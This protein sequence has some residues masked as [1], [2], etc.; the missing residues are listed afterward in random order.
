CDIVLSEHTYELCHDHIWVRELD[1]I[2]VKG[3]MQPVKI[4]GLIG[5]R[6]QALDDSTQAFLALYEQARQ[7]YTS[8]AFDEAIQLFEQAQQMRPADRAVEIHLQ[9]A[10]AYLQTPPPPNWDGV[11][12]MTTK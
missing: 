7:S 2:R 11:H 12:V 6:E 3:K 1:V 10:Q 5:D 4:Y 8:M 9:R